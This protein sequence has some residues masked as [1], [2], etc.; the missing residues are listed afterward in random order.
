M[1]TARDLGKAIASSWQERLKFGITKP[2][3]ASGSPPQE[4]PTAASGAGAPC[5]PPTSPRAGA[6]S[7]PR[8]AST[9]SRCPPA[10]P[11]SPD[12]LWHR[13]ASACDRTRR[14]RRTS[15]SASSVANESL[16]VVE[17][18][19]L[20][21]VNGGIDGRD[22][23]QSAEVAVAARPARPHHPRPDRA[24]SPSGSP[25]PSRGGRAAGRPGDRRHHRGRATTSTATS[26]TCAR[27]RVDGPPAG[28]RHRRR[29][30]STSAAGRAR[31][32]ARVG[33]RGGRRRTRSARRRASPARRPG[34][35]Q[36]R[37]SARSLARLRVPLRATARVG[38]SSGASPSWRPRW[39]PSRALHL[40]VATLSDVVAEL[41]LPLADQ[42]EE[43]TMQALQRPPGPVA[44]TG[45]ESRRSA[46]ARRDGAGL[47][48]RC[49]AGGELVDLAGASP[50]LEVAGRENLRSRRRSP[51]W[52]RRPRA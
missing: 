51:R 16:G 28:G 13:F 32:P 17:A 47:A 46:A 9:S 12:E 42:D 21:R 1:I 45:A 29:G 5:S 18:E 38:R 39:R 30:R 8:T 19:L 15:T 23:G 33:A 14:G 36:G 35:G 40:R 31:R 4:P 25:T 26:T 37:P 2:L 52:S 24:S 3:R 50:S 7:L 22:R 34:G 11:A 49:R 44:V 27:R 43:I 6:P 41:L 10:A 20:R 48:G